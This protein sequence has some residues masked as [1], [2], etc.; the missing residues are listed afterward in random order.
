M[1]K[2][3]SK[4]FMILLVSIMMT[5]LAAGCG[6]GSNKGNGGSS[7]EPAQTNDS[8]GKEP[9]SSGKKEKLVYYG[10]SEWTADPAIAPVLEE[11]KTKFAAEN[12]GYEVEFQSDPWGSWET[13]YKVMFASGNGPDVFIVNN[14]DFPAFANSGY[15]LDLGASLGE[16]AFKDFFPGILSMYDWSGKHMALP[17]TTDAR[18]LWYNKEIFKQAGLDPEK[19]PATWSE[20]KQYAAQITEATGGKVAGFGMDLGLKEFPSQSLFT[21]SPGSII[22]VKDGAITPNVNTPEFKGYLQLLADM[23]PSYEADYATLDHLKLGTLFAQKKVAMVIAGTWITDQNPDL[24]GA[25]FYG[26]A[27]V[28]KMDANAPDGSFGGGFGIAVA[29]NTKHP[30][31]AAKL[32]QML[33]SVDFNARTMTDVP[34]N[35]ASLAVSKFATDP[36]YAIFQEQIKFARQSQPKT[37]YYKEIDSAVYDTVT[38]VIVGNLAIDKAI[39]DLENKIKE[40]AAQK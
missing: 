33:T 7:S 39:A 10:F 3:Y 8:K 13:K 26:Q 27:L 2:R 19:P 38:K 35:N 40:I 32:A 11:L 30:E 5:A 22:E 25:D 28:P 31:A 4:V 1:Q 20:L 23:K 17:Y 34:A 16:D 24:K 21:A 37:L 36:A 18:V 6:N 12:P 14:P 29:A 9:A 15:L